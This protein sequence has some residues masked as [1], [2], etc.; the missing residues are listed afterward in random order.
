[1]H[2]SVIFVG[3]ILSA[4]LLS[5]QIFGADPDLI[6]ADERLLQTARIGTDGPSLVEYFRKQKPA[7]EQLEKIQALIRRL[8]DRS[9]EVREKAS[10]ELAGVGYSAAPLLRQAVMSSDPEISR[11]AENCLQQLSRESGHFPLLAV[12]AEAGIFR[13]PNGTGVIFALL[14]YQDLREKFFNPSMT[15]AAARLLGWRKP[16]GAAQVLLDYLPFAPDEALAEEVEAALAE[17]AVRG[18]GAEPAV[19]AALTDKVSL[20]R[21]AAGVALCRAGLA[22][23][24]SL[25]RPLLHDPEPTVRLRVA[26]VLAERREQE[27]IPVLIALLTQ[28]GPAQAAQVEEFLREIAGEQA[29]PTSPGI[30]ADSRRKCRDAWGAW[31]QGLDGQALLEVLRQRIL[32]DRVLGLIRQL[33]DDNYFVREQASARLTALGAMAL[34]VLRQALKDRDPEVALRAQKCKEIVEARHRPLMQV[35]IAQV[36]GLSA[37]GLGIPAALVHLRCLQLVEPDGTATIPSATARLLAFRKPP[38]AAQTLLAYL[39][40]ADDEMQTEEI[41]SALVALALHDHRPNDALIAAL[42]DRIPI[43]RTTAAAALCRAGALPDVPAIRQLLKDPD[44]RVRL[45]VALTLAELEDKEVIP[46]LITFLTDLPED[47]AWQA[48]DFLRRL[49]GEEGPTVTLAMD[50]TSRRM[51]R[52]AWTAWWSRNETRLDLAILAKTPRLLGYTIVAEYTDGQNGRVL[53]LGPNGKPRWTVENIPWPLEVQVLAGNRLLLAEYYTQRVTE[54]NFKGEVLWQKQLS[55]R[56]LNVQRLANGNTFIATQNALTEVDRSGEKIAGVI[57]AGILMA[58][59]LRGGRIAFIDSKGMFSLLDSS[60]RELKSF[61]VG[62]AQSYCSF[63]ILPNGN[64][65]VPLNASNQV[66][67]YDSQG[68]QVW[69]ARVQRPTSVARLPNGHTLA[70]CRDFQLVVELDRSGKEVWQYKSSGY[71]WRAYRR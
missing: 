43:R 18:H 10:K 22:P 65:L 69:K 15:A 59:K 56:P 3:L 52:N 44:P 64:L 28:L 6:A 7:G 9:Y 60:G 49:A 50:D 27:A 61:H 5:G 29:P 36:T 12:A 25:V 58:Q 71:P 20:R 13:Q 40:F 11:R 8:G 51:A 57:H 37:S 68:K 31:W 63:Q 14:G 67:E 30:T 23:M 19:L 45:R 46:L 54:R 62:A 39:P 66:V 34:P 55:E 17:V 24:I 32:E 26:M 16:P 48:E 47:L 53:E 21:A 1:M 41:E 35:G 38:G 70:S 33:G 2:R 42:E 4:L